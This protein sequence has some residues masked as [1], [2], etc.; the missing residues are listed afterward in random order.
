MN[1]L[2]IGPQGSGKGTQAEKICT[3]FRL[4][5]LEA[6]ALIRSEA[7]GPSPKAVI[8]DHLVNKKGQLLPDGVVLDLIADSLEQTGF[9]Q[10]LFDGFPRTLPQ[11]DVLTEFLDE[12]QA[13][14]DAAI[15]LTLTD[16][17]AVTRLSTRRVCET[18][19][20]PY[21]LA[22]EPNREHC[23]C[24]GNLI[25]RNDDQPE[26]IKQRLH[27]FHQST[28]PILDRLKAENLLV[29]VDGGQSIDEVFAA[30]KAGLGSKLTVS[31][32]V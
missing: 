3:F 17:V 28:Q 11:F 29:E 27:I 23:D 25:Q 22:L 9:D 2:L 10:I 26:A 6:G 14:I 4:H 8:I 24:G 15:Y 21:S 5:H 20:K 7:Q 1:I 18:C 32:T 19:H 13:K 30:V 16:E 12:H 31:R